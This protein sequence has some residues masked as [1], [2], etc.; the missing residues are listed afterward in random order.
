MTI[1]TIERELSTQIQEAIDRAAS[2]FGANITVQRVFEALNDI[3]VEIAVNGDEPTTAS[4]QVGQLDLPSVTLQVDPQGVS[5]VFPAAMQ[6]LMSIASLMSST[7]QSSRNEII[8]DSLTNA[9]RILIDRYSYKQV[10]SE[11]NVALA[12]N[13]ID[14]VTENFREIV[15]KAMAQI[16]KDLSEYGPNN[17]P[18][19]EYEL[20][21]EADLEPIPDNVVTVVPKGYIQRYRKYSE[22][23]Y[24]GYEEWYS[25]QTGETVY[26]TREVNSYYFESMQEEIYGSSETQL[27]DS[28]DPYI[29]DE[30]LILTVDILNELLEAQ[31]VTIKNSSMEKAAGAGSSVDVFGLLQQLLPHI[32]V[33]IDLQRL[34]QL[35]ESVLDVSGINEAL[36]EFTE[37]MAMLGSLNEMIDEALQIPSAIQDL[38][39][40]NLSN[41]TSAL[42]LDGIVSNLNI[43]LEGINLDIGGE[44]G[45]QLNT[46]V[47]QLNTVASQLEPSLRE[48]VDT[49]GELETLR[50]NI[51]L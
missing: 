14:R 6:Q 42:N 35:P 13:G 20:I 44:I 30:T 11:F 38:A 51:R 49:I 8:Y 47:N 29:E 24:K 40:I 36:D 25:K 16:I 37:N 28:L 46:A 31:E 19:P 5:S 32:T 26:L 10:I 48:A 9:I 50:F 21:T 39:N 45:A 34:V 12:N 22:D 4:A 1:E 33:T 15:R 27:A 17:I 41:I 7:T 18:V 3:R 43:N 23:P 2:Q